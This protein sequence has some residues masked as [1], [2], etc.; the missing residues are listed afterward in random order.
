MVN[1]VI[2]HPLTI[3]SVRAVRQ[4]LLKTQEIS[5]SLWQQHLMG[6]VDNKQENSSNNNKCTALMKAEITQ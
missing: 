1:I 5:E 3:R 2:I 4:I 6:S